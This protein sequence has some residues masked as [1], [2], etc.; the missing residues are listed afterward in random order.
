MTRQPKPSGRKPAANEGRSEASYRRLP[1]R[2]REAR[3]LLIVC[4]GKETEPR[5]FEALR[6]ELR[7]RTLKIEVVAGRGS[8]GAIVRTA[9]Q[10][11]SELQLSFEAGDQA[12]CVFDT[13]Q[14]GT[15]PDL[16]AVIEHAAKAGLF[17]AA[18]NPAF[19][20]WYLLHFESTN[21]PF[22]HATEVIERLRAYLP[23]YAK[24]SN[25]FA[26]LKDRTVTALANA[27][28]LRQRADE[29]WDQCPNPS[30]G[31]DKLVQQDLGLL[32]SRR[33]LRRKADAPRYHVFPRAYPP[34]KSTANAISIFVR[35]SSVAISHDSS[36]PC[37][38]AG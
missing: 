7:L 14:Q 30:T 1:G 19:E 31:V 22:V 12:W 3:V 10:K 2:R 20:Y 28:A 29:N 17:L 13:E 5:Y 25:V 8:P 9:L 37:T 34:N 36:V 32:W 23:Q 35:K 6:N 18:S 27:T 26:C 38:P 15:H 33:V 24:T 4:E 11:Q 16:A 21:R